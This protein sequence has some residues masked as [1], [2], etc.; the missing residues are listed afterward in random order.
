MIQDALSWITP[1]ALLRYSQELGSPLSPNDSA[2]TL[3]VLV[4]AYE[5]QENANLGP[6]EYH[7][8]EIN[9]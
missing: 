3:Q 2:W 6:R 1:E 7:N 9:S 8:H 5:L 4:R